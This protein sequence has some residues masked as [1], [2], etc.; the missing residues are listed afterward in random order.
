MVYND[1]LSS[2]KLAKN[3]TFHTRSK[4]ID[5]KYLKTYQRNFGKQTVATKI[6]IK[7]NGN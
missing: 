5:I 1:S 7:G 2:L 3:L 6:H 4:P